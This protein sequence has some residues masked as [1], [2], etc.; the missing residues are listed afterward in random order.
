MSPLMDL[1]RVKNTTSSVVPHP[2]KVQREQF[3]SVP[4][5]LPAKIHQQTQLDITP[6]LDATFYL[7]PVVPSFRE[8]MLPTSPLS[9][10]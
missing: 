2:P 10:T 8:W 9:W 3:D 6:R 5:S 4:P 1:S 7:D